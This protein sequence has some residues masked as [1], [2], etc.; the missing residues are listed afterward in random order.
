MTREWI[1]ISF[2]D[3]EGEE[4]LQQ[5]LAGLNAQSELRQALVWSRL[6]G[7]GAVLMGVDDGQTVDQP[8]KM[9]N[10]RALNFLT[11][12]DR[13]VLI[14]RTYYND[15]LKPQFGTVETYYL[16]VSY[17]GGLGSVDVNNLQVIVHE[18]RMLRFYGTQLPKRYAYTQQGWGDSVL[19]R[20]YDIVRDTGLSWASMA[21]LLQ[22]FSQATFKMRG[23]SQAMLS[24]NAQAVT[25]R[26]TA[27]DMSRSTIRAVLL[28][29]DGEEF[30]RESTPVSGLAELLDKLLL[31]LAAAAR[32]PVTL[33]MGQAPAGLNATGDGD[34][35]GFYDRIASEQ[36]NNL[37]PGLEKLVEVALRAKNNGMKK[38]VDAE[39][40]TI[41][42]NPLWQM[43][44]A[45]QATIRLQTAQA[46]AIY[47]TNQVLDPDE[48]ALSRFGSDEWSMQTSLLMDR[49][50]PPD[51]PRPE[52]R[53][54][55]MTAAMTPPPDDTTT[56]AEKDEDQSA[57]K[58]AKSGTGT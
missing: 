19:T 7:G 13:Y 10:V 35:R 57:K 26:M 17:G 33:L 38:R 4:D 23:L 2:D 32:I 40:F 24:N 46:D 58:G 43:T 47:L 41:T 6:M 5:F 44:D 1:K 55:A 34:I 18:S 54:A 39:S 20:C 52:D 8:L 14:P 21:T 9:E 3:G 11:S 53:S 28:D 50:P 45:E 49:S 51:M 36:E 12:L 25:D 30:K 31:R 37:R 22:D 42:F 27:I 56:P 15:P 29:A 48:V 16:Q